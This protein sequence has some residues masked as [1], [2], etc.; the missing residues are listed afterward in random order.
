MAEQ[1]TAPGQGSAGSTDLA[2]Q[3]QGVVRQLTNLY[4]NGQE[5]IAAI[6][7]VNFP[8]SV[9]GYTVATLP[10]SPSI[11]MLAFITNGASALAWGANATASTGAVTYLVWWNGTQWSVLG[12]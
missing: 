1:P 6:Q 8:Q 7:A 12:K 3:L 11:G 5:L 10:S 4:K 9:K 2:T